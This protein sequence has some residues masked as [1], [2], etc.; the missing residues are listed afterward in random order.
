MVLTRRTYSWDFLGDPAVRNLHFHCWGHRFNPWW[1]NLDPTSIMTQPKKEKKNSR[2]LLP[3]QYTFALQKD[4]GTRRS[5]SSFYMHE[6][7]VASVVSDS[8]TLW[9]VACQA[10][11][12]TGFPGKN[13]GVG[14]YAFLPGIFQT[15]GSNLHLLHLLHW[16]VGSLL[17]VPPGK[18]SCS[19]HQCIKSQ[20]VALGPGKNTIVRSPSV[21]LLS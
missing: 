13:T 8:V 6:C 1:G 21:N 7:E 16:Q 15:Q 3:R 14:W 2:L 17:L 19:S 9:T 11:L 20:T 5:A 18:P 10:P 12:S 4:P